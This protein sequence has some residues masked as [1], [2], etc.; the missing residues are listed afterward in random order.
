MKNSSQ[1]GFTLIE[2]LVAIAIFAFSITGLI[3]VTGQGVSNT[4][5]VKNKFTAGYLALEGAELVRNVRDT[6]SIGNLAW[7]TIFPGVGV[8]SYLGECMSIDGES[9]T[10]DPWANPGGPVVIAPCSGDCPALSYNTS[11]G[12]FSY[13]SQNN[14]N[15]FASIFTRT[16]YILPVEPPNAYEKTVVSEV[17]WTQGSRTHKVVH[18]FNLMD[19]AGP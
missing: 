16:I 4:T 5:F 3:V 7:A 15:I 2:T 12:R 19:W 17:S 8:D 9:C 6:A 18:T 14:I 11:T 10:I 13:E 1:K